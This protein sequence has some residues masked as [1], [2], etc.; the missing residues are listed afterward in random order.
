[1][2]ITRSQLR[3][4]IQEAV[5]AD[6]GKQA[7]RLRNLQDELVAKHGE[8]AVEFHYDEAGDE[9]YYDALEFAETLSDTEFRDQMID[10]DY[11]DILDPGAAKEAESA[12]NLR[13]INYASQNRRESERR[14]RDKEREIKAAAEAGYSADAAGVAAMYRD[15][16]R[17]AYQ[18]RQNPYASGMSALEES[19]AETE[20]LSRGSLYRKRYHGRY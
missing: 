15:D 5:S 2:K 7:E 8:H 19:T 9:S 10:S 1:M 17:A 20:S 16:M 6:Y 18:G 14:K 12:A 13:K 3:Q 11:I 4:L